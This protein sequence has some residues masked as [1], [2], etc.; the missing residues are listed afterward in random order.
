MLGLSTDPAGD[1]LRVNSGHLA[2]RG[3]ITLVLRLVTPSD[4]DESASGGILVGI[5][6]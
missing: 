6:D 2:R 1:A 4:S 5:R 3:A